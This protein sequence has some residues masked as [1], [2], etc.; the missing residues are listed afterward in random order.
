[1]KKIIFILISLLTLVLTSCQDDELRSENK[2]WKGYVGKHFTSET[3]EFYWR[4]DKRIDDYTTRIEKLYLNEGEFVEFTNLTESCVTFRYGN[5]DR[6]FYN[7]ADATNNKINLTVPLPYSV[8]GIAPMVEFPLI[9]SYQANNPCCF[10]DQTYIDQ[11]GYKFRVW[12]QMG[13]YLQ[14]QKDDFDYVCPMPRL[15]NIIG[16]QY[17]KT[18][19]DWR[20]C[21]FKFEK[22][23]LKCS[24][25]P[26]LIK[27]N[28]TAWNVEIA[29]LIPDVSDFI[30]LLI[31]IPILKREDYIYPS[32]YMEDKGEYLSIEELVTIKFSGV[33]QYSFPEYDKMGK[34][35]STFVDHTISYGGSY[36]F[37]ENSIIVSKIDDRNLCVRMDADSILSRY[38]LPK[39]KLFFANTM[40][41]L[42]SEDKCHFEMQYELIDCNL[43]IKYKEREFHMTLTNPQHSRNIMEYVILP[44]I[45]ENREA[46]KD[47]IRQDAELSQHADVLCAA[48]DRLEDIYAG[49]TDLTLGY[50]LIE[51]QL[52]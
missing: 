29:S 20:V 3:K 33:R 41:S 21:P 7:L 50:R 43:N 14:I 2:G 18:Y 25:S 24:Q 36:S 10:F 37:K 8:A 47:Y 6:K 19:R 16:D 9:F 35:T 27:W 12:G 26:I 46:I 32:E 40:R 11:Y 39:D 30:Q 23:T 38:T 1:M 5:E 51:H 49:T 42:L 17:S 52:E 4:H 31:S 44:L 22:T 34:P 48:V 28:S 13:E 15:R 45:I